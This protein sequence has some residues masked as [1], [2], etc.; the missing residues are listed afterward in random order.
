MINLHYLP[1]DQKSETQNYH[2]IIQDYIKLYYKLFYCLKI[3][4]IN[5]L[6]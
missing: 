3:G 1:D 6:Q 4:V 2:K 5:L